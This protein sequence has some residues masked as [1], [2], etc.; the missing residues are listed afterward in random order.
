MI[1]YINKENAIADS[2]KPEKDWKFSSEEK[3]ISIIIEKLKANELYKDFEVVKADNNGR[4]E[5]KIEKTIPVNIR[6]VML[7]ELEEML[8]TSVDKS[9]T[10]WLVPVGDKSKLR[11]LRGIKIK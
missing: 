7:L 5:L 10:V 9:I 6:G 11:N 3:R 8:K 4:I 1:N 2:P